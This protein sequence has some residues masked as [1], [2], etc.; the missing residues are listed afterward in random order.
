MSDFAEATRVTWVDEGGYR[1]ELSADWTVGDKPH[2]GYLLALLARAGVA[3]LGDLDPLAL[4]AEF[5][6]PPSAGPATLRT[7]IRKT[8]RTASVVTV[9]LEQGGRDCVTGTL[10]AGALP[11]EDA[12]WSDLPDF[13]AEPEADALDFGTELEGPSN[14]G[15]RTELNISR[16]NGAIFTDRRAGDPL[17]LRGWARQPPEHTDVFFALVACDVLPPLTFNLGRLGWSPTVQLTA[18]LRAKPAPGWLRVQTEARSVSGN[19]FDSDATVLDSRG[20]LVCQA[21][22]LA[23]AAR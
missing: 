5:L 19:W 10:T 1:A 14:V 6:R 12:V 3:A 17:Q 15:K 18:L 9:R 8:G 16:R 7:D 2:G 4:S 22:Q 21:R 11:D 20:R 13:P 23:L